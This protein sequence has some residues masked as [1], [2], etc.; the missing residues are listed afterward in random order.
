MKEYIF[1]IIGTGLDNYY[2]V[3]I[4]ILKNNKIISKGKTYN[5]KYKV[6]LKSNSIYKIK[7]N[8]CTYIIYTN[9]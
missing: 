6:C 3:D 8:N 7:I 2:Q 5:G 9:Q 4:E 1:N